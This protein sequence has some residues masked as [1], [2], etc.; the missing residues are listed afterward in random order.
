[1]NIEQ[2]NIELRIVNSQLRA[3]L[4]HAT[5]QQVELGSEELTQHDGE[6][7]DLIAKTVAD[8]AVVAKLRAQILRLEN[9]GKVV[10][11]QIEQTDAMI[12][13][14]VG[15]VGA[16]RSIASGKLKRLLISL[17]L[18]VRRLVAATKNPR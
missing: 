16:L 14:Q 7:A 18:A 17:R 12:Q 13:N 2:R 15:A 3:M 11:G 5:A 9:R 4:E 8:E 6:Y 10:R 1:M